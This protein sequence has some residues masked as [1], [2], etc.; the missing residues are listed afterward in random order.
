[1][2]RKQLFITLFI[3]CCMVMQTKEYHVSI[4]GNDTNARTEKAP[5]WTIGEAAEYAFPGG[6]IT[7]HAGIYRE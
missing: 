5:F 7:M 6:I 1:M 3:V 2:K 4:K